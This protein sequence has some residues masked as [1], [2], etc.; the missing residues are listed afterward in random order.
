MCEWQVL[1]GGHLCQ[2]LCHQLV[3]KWDW[4]R[5]GGKKGVYW[6]KDIT[7]AGDVNEKWHWVYICLLRKEAYEKETVFEPSL[8]DAAREYVK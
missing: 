8:E 4:D 6:A 7:A 3:N 2:P 1:K 5:A